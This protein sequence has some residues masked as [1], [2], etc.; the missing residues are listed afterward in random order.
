MNESPYGVDCPNNNCETMPDEVQPCNNAA[1]NQVPAYSTSE[2]T[3]TPTGCNEVGYEGTTN[4][5]QCD[6]DSPTCVDG[7]DNDCDGVMDTED[8]K[9]YCMSPIVIDTLGDGFSLTSAADGVVFDITG[10]GRPL[11]LS[12][13]RGDDAWLA[14]DRDGNGS[15]DNGRELFGNFSPQPQPLPGELKNGFLALA[16][17]DKSEQ[18]GNGDGVIDNRD[19]VFVNLRLWRDADRDGF[20]DAGE[21]KTL[22]DLDVAVLE[23]NYRDSRRTDKHGNQFKYRAKVRDAKGAKVNRW[24]WDVFLRSAP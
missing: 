16:E 1:V 23:L 13:T 2:P 15:I 21:L 3:P 9:C 24:A 18:G 8:P 22:P 5:G 20:S 7:I 17:Y 11:R 19:A 4:V 12:W 10:T 6:I 14:L